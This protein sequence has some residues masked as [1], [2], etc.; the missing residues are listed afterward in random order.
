MRWMLLIVEDEGKRIRGGQTV[1]G[2]RCVS[3]PHEIVD[4]LSN[5]SKRGMQCDE[6][7]MYYVASRQLSRSIPHSRIHKDVTCVIRE[8][9]P[10]FPL[11]ALCV[12]FNNGGELT[13]QPKLG[14]YVFQEASKKFAALKKCSV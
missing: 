1:N 10:L 8:D 4:K 11:I 7:G 2:K 9:N 13:R 14:Q 12:G 6:S 3:D 5:E